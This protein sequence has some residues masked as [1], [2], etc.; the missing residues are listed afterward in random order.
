MFRIDNKSHSEKRKQKVNCPKCMHGL[1]KAI[2]ICLYTCCFA[3]EGQESEATVYLWLQILTCYWKPEG[4][5]ISGLLGSCHWCE[6]D[7]LVKCFTV[8][9]ITPTI[10]KKSN[11]QLQIKETTLKEE[12]KIYFETVETVFLFINTINSWLF[13]HTFWQK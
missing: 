11:P 10:Y 9:L 3:K 6:E 2:Y 8:F 12:K 4:K 13:A 1:Y 7:N 5:R